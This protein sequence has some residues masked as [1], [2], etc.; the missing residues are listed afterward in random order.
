[1]RPG[2]RKVWLLG[3]T[4]AATA[5]AVQLL[6][7]GRIDQL[8]GTPSLPWW[9]V[10]LGFAAAEVLVVHVQ[11]RREAHSFS[12]NEIPLVVGLFT[13]AP[14]ELVL[15][16]V[17][18][19][20]LSLVLHRRQ[21]PVKLV[22]NLAQ[23]ALG[24][25]M[26]ALCTHAIAG[27]GDPLGPAA[28]AG[29]LTGVL[30]ATL[31][32]AVAVSAAIYLREGRREREVFP[33][34]T[35]IAM[36]VAFGSGAVGLLGVELLSWNPQA[37]WLLAVPAALML[38]LYRGYAAELHR[39]Q[40]LRFLYEATRTA[41]QSIR[42]EEVMRGLLG[43][44]RD[45]FRAD[46]GEIVF[47]AEENAPP[48]RTV[49]GPGDVAA[50]L[51]EVTLDP[52]DGVWARI[53][54]EGQ[55]VLIRRPIQND[56]LRAHFE[57]R[58]IRDAM[59]A[60]LLS[61]TRVVGM[62]T[63]ANRR[64]DVTTFDQADLQLFQ[65][66][67]NHVSVALENARLVRR[68]EESLDHLTEMNRLKDDFVA[69]VSHEL[70][71][72]LTSVQ[73]AIKTLIRSGDKIDAGT[74]SMLLNAADRQSDRLRQLI[75]NLLIVSQIESSQ[76][77]ADVDA[78]SVGDV[79]G[80]VLEET[81]PI[82]GPHRVAVAVEPDLPLVSTD[83]GKLHQIVVNLVENALKYSPK[84]GPVSVRVVRQGEGIILSV[85]DHGTGIPADLRDRVFERFFQVDQTSTR[86]I[87]GTGLGLYICRQL[88]QTLGGRLWIE[89]SGETGSVFSLWLPL[90]APV[91]E[92]RPRTASVPA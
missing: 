9:G 65:T 78:V 42:I 61:G 47:F 27:L 91:R 85:E 2:A 31:M 50:I 70:R 41:H 73:G 49:L 38:A 87:G 63:V 3:L 79:V 21:P 29:A 48:T 16:Q 92:G 19:A 64:G 80:R 18:G 13:L 51:E 56:R 86:R 55:P 14:A 59:V 45:M 17:A 8:P 4:V 39:H 54:S 32:G 57:D 62:I 68:L 66:L 34:A 20:A 88:A 5:T 52:A 15:A 6:G 77:I 53:A 36:G 43:R 35:A 84:D 69:T 10:A 40:G 24:A 82:E 26:A 67:A 81:Q 11:F 22:F 74:E 46:V 23:L 33:T 7:M 71:T 60:P 90:S 89:R 12:L 76:V 30:V 37:L 44:A 58:G 83:E 28:W 72:P 1:M 75:E 25:Q